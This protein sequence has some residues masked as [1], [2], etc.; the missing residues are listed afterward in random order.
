MG[1]QLVAEVAKAQAFRARRPF[2]EIGRAVHIM[3]PEAA[4][5][6]ARASVRSNGAPT[7]TDIA[8]DAVGPDARHHRVQPHR[9]AV[10]LPD[11]LESTKATA[12]GTGDLEGAPLAGAQQADVRAFIVGHVP[13]RLVAKVP[14][15]AA[16]CAQSL[17][18]IDSPLAEALLAAELPSWR[19]IAMAVE[20]AEA[21]AMLTLRRAVDTWGLVRAGI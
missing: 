7:V 5:F 8:S 15:P 17:V 16:Q 14:M 11:F 21:V 18:A 3:A 2:G 20:F 4:A 13:V 10:P 19:C 9:V 12:A 1:T 6:V